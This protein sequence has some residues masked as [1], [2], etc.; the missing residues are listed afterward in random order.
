MSAER[1]ELLQQPLATLKLSV[2]ASNCLEMANIRTIGDLARNSADELL[3]LR[4]FGR[5]SLAEV[6]ALLRSHG[7]CLGMSEADL[8]RWVRFGE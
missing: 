1:T 7:L 8:R 4:S 3:R 2:R 6:E 5:T